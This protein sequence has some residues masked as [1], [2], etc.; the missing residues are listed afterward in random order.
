MQESHTFFFQILAQQPPNPMMQLLFPVLLLVGMWFLL[1]AP[2][3]KR[4]KEQDKMLKAISAGDQIMTNGGIY[5]TVISAKNER[6]IVKISD[7]TRIELDKSAVSKKIKKEKE[8][9]K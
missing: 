9:E 1:V 6:L 8:D 7:N 4:Q 2:Q 3:R 5:G